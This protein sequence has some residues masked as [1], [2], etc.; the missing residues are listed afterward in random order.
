MCT[1]ALF[2]GVERPRREVNPSPSTSEIN[3][4]YNLTPLTH[5]SLWRVTF[6]LLVPDLILRKIIVSKILLVLVKEHLLPSK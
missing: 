2:P 5:T 6:L 4:I 3:N 1:G